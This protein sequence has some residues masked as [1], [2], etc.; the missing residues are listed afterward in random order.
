MYEVIKCYCAVISKKLSMEMKL[1]IEMIKINWT[2]DK[3]SIG[4][5]D[6]RPNAVSNVTTSFFPF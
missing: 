4:I 2:E 5:H 3:Q 1:L 6:L